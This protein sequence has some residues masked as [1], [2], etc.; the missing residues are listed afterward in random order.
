[1]VAEGRAQIA[2]G[3][4]KPAATHSALSAIA[5]TPKV[6]SAQPRALTAGGLLPDYCAALPE[7][8]R[9]T[10]DVPAK[11]KQPARKARGSIEGRPYSN[12]PARGNFGESVKRTIGAELRSRA[13]P[14]QTPPHAGI[15]ANQSNELLGLSHEQR[16]DIRTA[17]AAGGTHPRLET[18]GA[19]LRTED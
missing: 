17:G 13:D 1:M 2:W 14:T 19:V 11:G 18:V 10:I 5:L 4:A 3:G 16:L 6:R 9:E 7:Q 8:A 12:S 15:S